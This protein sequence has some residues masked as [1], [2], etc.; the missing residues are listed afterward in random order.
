MTGNACTTVVI[1]V[2]KVAITSMDNVNSPTVSATV[3][4]ELSHWSDSIGN[5][6]EAERDVLSSGLTAAKGM[7]HFPV[8][9]LTSYMRC[10]RQT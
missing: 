5:M 10:W 6:A 3:S 4:S 1:Q 7:V 9:Y 2:N 8:R